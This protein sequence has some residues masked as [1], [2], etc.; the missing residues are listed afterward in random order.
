MKARL[1]AI[2]GVQTVGA[3]NA[4][5][6]QGY[7]GTYYV[8][9][10]QDYQD[11]S[12]RRIVGFKYVLPG[13]FEALDIPVLRGRGLLES[14]GPGATPVAVVN[15][16]L[17]QLLWPDSNPLGQQIV[18]SSGPREVVGV[19]ADTRDAGADEDA[20]IMMFMSAYQAGVRL[21]D[22]ALEA[23]VP[24]ST[25][26]EPARAAVRAVDPNVPAYDVMTL[27]ALIDRTLGGDTIMAK[28]MSVLALIALVLALG[29]VYGVMAYTVSQRTREMGIRL[30]L[31]AQRANVMA[32]VV[33]Q[34]TA[35][36]LMGIVLGLA[37]ALGVT[38]GLSRFLFGVSPFD[39]LTFVSV[40]AVLLFAGV[41]ATLFPAR[42]ATRVD[43]VVA[44]RAE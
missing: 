5:P 17:A 36:A 33:R 24:L 32:M 34:G 14:D 10:G 8:L 20:P 9:G 21:M 30:S 44:L 39:P 27:N 22:W 12:L 35:L 25:L 37:V 13:Y 28:I 43:P 11:P 26:A 3:T 38:R 40:S 4:L 16:T 2:P 18:L 1:E 41:V 42:R 15:Q 6:L 31:G 19:V 29:G 7:S 23:S